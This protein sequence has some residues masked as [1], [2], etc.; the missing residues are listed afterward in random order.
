MRE[1][2][3]ISGTCINVSDQ[4]CVCL[5]PQGLPC[6]ADGPTEGAATYFPRNGERQV[7][8]ARSQFFGVQ[9]IEK[10]GH[11]VLGDIIAG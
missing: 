4:H 11:E 9:K 3:V 5:I 8:V 1:G 2:I 10:Y 6:F 7:G